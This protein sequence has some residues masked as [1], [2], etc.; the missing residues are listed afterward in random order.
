MARP[1]IAI[2][3]QYGSGGKTIGQMLADD[4]NI[5]C[6]E[7]EI[8]SMASEDSGI[9]ESLFAKVDERIGTNTIFK[10]K[11]I[12]KGNLI[13]PESE[14]FTSDQN[15]FNYQAKIIKQLAEQNP[16]VIIGR[17]GN[18]VLKGNPDVV[19]V[20]V[21]ANPDFLLKNAMERVSFTEKETIK[22]IEKT[23]KYRADYY[24]YYTGEDWYDLR[25]YDLAL[26]SSKLGFEGCVEEIK[27]YMKIRGLV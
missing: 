2:A 8:I 23:N 16:C 11:H 6:Y 24:K 15:L 20:F 14:G 17:C 12:Y 4:L 18:F 22:Y 3:R 7:R 13:S 26:D 27:A 25:H 5:N 21:H 9:S 10:M 1:I 19:S